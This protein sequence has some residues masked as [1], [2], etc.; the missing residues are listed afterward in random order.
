MTPN[1]ATSAY[2]GSSGAVLLI[3]DSVLSHSLSNYTLDFDAKMDLLSGSGFFG[4]AVRGT[5]NYPNIVC[6][7]FILNDDPENTVPHWQACTLSDLSGNNTGYLGGSFYGGGSSTPT[8]TAGT[9]FHFKVVCQGNNIACYI[10]AGSGSALVF[11][12]SDTTNATGG[13]GFSTAFLK[14]PNLVHFKNLVVSSCP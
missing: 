11:C 6:Y 13:V 2:S 14:T 3:K 1:S 12:F 9:W 10:D 7:T 4:S 5:L 8:Y